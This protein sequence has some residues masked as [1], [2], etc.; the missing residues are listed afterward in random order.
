MS[1][2]M[3][4]ALIL[5]PIAGGVIYAWIGYVTI[6]QH[7][8]GPEKPTLGSLIVMGGVIGLAFEL[9]A[10]IPFYLALRHW[11]RLRIVTFV[12]GGIAAWFVLSTAFL[13]ALGY[14]WNGGTA[15]AV[16]MLPVGV[17]VVLTFWLLGRRRDGA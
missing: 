3:W 1:T 4:F 2:R 13:V 14:G 15:T 12:P 8:T 7:V 6:M 9:I 17:S 16:S 10:L 11:R 5:A